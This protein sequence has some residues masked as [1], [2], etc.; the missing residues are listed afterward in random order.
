[1]IPFG[2]EQ[3]RRSEEKGPFVFRL[4]VVDE[5]LA[6]QISSSGMSASRSITEGSFAW[7][8]SVLMIWVAVTVIC[9]LNALRDKPDYHVEDERQAELCA[10]RQKCLGVN[11]RRNGEVG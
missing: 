7:L 3:S 6:S 10:G 5:G 9:G 2:N 4:Y 11:H 1:M 8:L